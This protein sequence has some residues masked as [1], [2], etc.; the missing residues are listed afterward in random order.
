MLLLLPLLLS[1]RR[2]RDRHRQDA[3]DAAIALDAAACRGVVVDRLG[4]LWPSDVSELPGCRGGFIYVLDDGATI[5]L[6]TAAFDPRLVSLDDEAYRM[7]VAAL[8]TASS[9]ATTAAVRALGGAR[10]DT[11]AGAGGA[12]AGGGWDLVPNPH[13]ATVARLFRL[14]HRIL[15]VMYVHCCSAS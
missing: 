3:C 5:T 15:R 11:G 13:V 2:H 14:R 1:L 7:A 10:S 12:G 6:P 9:A 4:V 8:A